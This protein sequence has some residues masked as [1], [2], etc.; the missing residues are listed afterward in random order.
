MKTYKKSLQKNKVPCAEG[1]RFS[2]VIPE[3]ECRSEAT[4]PES[5]KEWSW[6]FFGLKVTLATKLNLKS[7]EPD[8]EI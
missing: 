3:V 5:L 7:H 2:V 4:K 6:V 1:G 8:S